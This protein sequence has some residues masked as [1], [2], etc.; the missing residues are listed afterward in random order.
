MI[1]HVAE[2][3]EQRGRVVLHLSSCQ[4]NRYAVE[5]A[6]R[7]A[8]AFQS[9]I[10]SV[11]VEDLQL[12]DLARFSFA[13]EISFDGRRRRALSP[14]V[15]EEQ[16]KL[17]ASAFGRQIAR[18][19]KGA[20]VP[21]RQTVVRGEPVAVLT[22]AC[23]DSGPWNVVV[24]SEPLTAGNEPMVNQLL[25]SVVGATGIIV[26]GPRA[27]RT[28]G[29]VVA[30]IEDLSHLEPMLRAAQRLLSVTGDAG[31]ILL[32]VTEN[33]EEGALMEDQARLVLGPEV[34]ARIM[35]A[36]ATHGTAIE[37]AEIVRR[38][39]G[40]FLLAQMGGILVPADG[41]LEHLAGALESPLFLVR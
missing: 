31:V 32:L 36:N 2:A 4:P 14:D 5:A 29:P 12:F 19:A 24:L 16:L 27:K 41:S 6:I 33:P 8:Q 3:G 9:E 23:E 34:A 17:N 30:A 20:D 25:A 35:V 37:L 13:S 26:A 39:H 7:V 22:R 18:L 10:E 28:A 38:L 21:L 40:G 11:F 1:A 15:L